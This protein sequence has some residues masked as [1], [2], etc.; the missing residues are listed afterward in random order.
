MIPIIIVIFIVFSI[1]STIKVL[2]MAKRKAIVRVLTQANVGGGQNSQTF[3][4]GNMT[5]TV[6]KPTIRTT[7]TTS[8]DLSGMAG[9]ILKS[10]GGAE[11][12]MN[13][14]AVQEALRNAT[15]QAGSQTSN[16]SAADPFTGST[17]S[18][19]DAG[20]SPFATSSSPF[21]PAVAP[22]PA[23]VGRQSGQGQMGLAQVLASPTT[24]FDGT[25]ELSLELD[26]IGSPKRR[27]SAMLDAGQTDDFAVGSRLYV[28]LDAQDSSKVYV[29]PANAGPKLPEGSNRLDMVVL[30]PQMYK[31][32]AHGKAVVKT[33]D[34]LSSAIGGGTWKLELDVTPER[35]WPY[36]AELLTTV[37]T[38]EKAARV[39]VVGAE[40]PVLYDPDDPKTMCLD[41]VALGYGNPFQGQ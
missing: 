22:P 38:P 21:Q 1:I 18:P 28:R 33:A 7:V 10:M 34:K 16:S 37:S 14:P 6:Q 5:V 32:G 35:G 39:C 11:G 19:F 2:Q 24:T 20:A 36:R 13:M 25:R 8:G 3:R 4:Q 31:N 9:D 12:I 17:S 15:Q 41:S 40:V 30:G 26:A 27:V 23:A 29:L